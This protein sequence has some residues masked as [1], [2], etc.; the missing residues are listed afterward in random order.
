MSLI[1]AIIIL[2]AIVYLMYLIFTGLRLVFWQI[3]GMAMNPVHGLAERVNPS[4]F[5]KYLMQYSV[6]FRKLPPPDRLKF[7]SRIKGFIDSKEFIGMEGLVVTDEMRILVAASAVQITFGL[8]LYILNQYERI[9]LF[10][11]EYKNKITGK[12][13]KG[14]VNIAGTIALSWNNLLAG[15]LN[16]VDNYNLGLHEMAH[17]LR[18]NSISGEETDEFFEEYIEKWMSVGDKE[19][20]RIKR[21]EKSYL[22]EYAGANREEFFAVCVE[23]FF[24]TSL[25]FREKLPE[26]YFHLALLLNQDPCLSAGYGKIREVVSEALV[27]QSDSGECIFSTSRLSFNEMNICKNFFYYK[28]GIFANR[29]IVAWGSVVS[30]SFWA[31]AHFSN[32]M[33]DLM[34]ATHYRRAEVKFIERGRI[35]IRNFQINRMTALELKPVIT[36]LRSK[37][38]L[39]KREKLE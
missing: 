36:F 5:Y 11:K 10:P 13:H 4:G 12:Y 6:Y 37:N 7:I 16:S 8:D 17:A 18:F 9:L 32:E 3:F 34:P 14:E 39:V 19:F 22:R 27:P 28:S 38:V 31:Y 15:Y 24:E 33:Y 1:P 29:K 20:E 23:H 25:E 35:E 26:I 2:A 21:G 30:V